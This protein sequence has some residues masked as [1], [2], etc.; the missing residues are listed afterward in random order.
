MSTSNYED[1]RTCPQILRFF[2]N[3]VCLFLKLEDEVRTRRVFYLIFE[4]FRGF[5]RNSSEFLGISSKKV[6]N[7]SNFEDFR[8]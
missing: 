3:E 4:D 5:P 1:P 7:S 8:G 6:Q 2:E